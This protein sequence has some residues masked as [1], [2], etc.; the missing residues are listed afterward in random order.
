MA[1]TTV[2]IAWLGGLLEGEGYFVINSKKKY[3]SKVCYDR[4]RRKRNKQLLRRVG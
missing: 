3:P 4:K 1:E 2:D